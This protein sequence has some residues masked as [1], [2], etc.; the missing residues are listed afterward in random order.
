MRAVADRAVDLR[1]EPLA[2]LRA[3]DF[4][5]ADRDYWAD[6]AAIQ[7]RF[8]ASWAGLDDAAWRLPGA[9]PSDAGGPDWSLLDHVAHI[10]DWHELA[11]DYITAVLAGGDW[12]S[13]DD[14]SAGDFDTFNETRRPLFADLAPAALRE[15]A[16]RAHE[17]V[18]AVARQLPPDTIRGDAAWGWVHQV[19]HGHA[20]DHLA[21]VEPWADA[22][23]QRQVRND[24]FGPDP[25][26][27]R[28]E[29]PAALE[30]FWA[31]EATVSALFDETVA[32]VPDAHWTSRTDGEWTVA[33]HVA[34]LAGWFEIA[35]D[36]LRQHAAG[37]EWME[38]P[39]E[40]LDAFND[41]QV[42][43]ARGESPPSLRQRYATGRDRLLDAVRAM[44]E[45][46]W[47]DPEGF[48]WAYEDLHG[49]VRA[50]LAM[51]GPWA[52]RAHWPAESKH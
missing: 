32:A 21:V 11:T 34:H 48:S 16:V 29:L 8:V 22:L 4:R 7:D 14:Y 25:Q 20:L 28:P 5:A 41:R 51:I 18:L 12:P 42:K 17:R 13:D 2:A 39:P 19:L 50:H 6:E 47:L 46:E 38:L 30:R 3:I 45:A 27:V 10:V 1:R 33:D 31:D 35:V 52:A 15:R 23:R 49:H 9:A 43:A 37:S 26:P 24:P 40:G 44:S 36:A